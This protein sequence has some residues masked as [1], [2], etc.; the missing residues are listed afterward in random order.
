MSCAVCGGT[1]LRPAFAAM[2]VS[3]RYES[4]YCRSCRMY[5]TIGDIAPV[6]PD[7]VDLDAADLDAPHR[8]LQTTHK[9][10]A[11][12]QW[13]ALVRPQ[14]GQQLLEIG[15]G[16]GGFLD[17]AAAQGVVVYGFDASHA[18]AAEARARHA[19]V[20]AAASIDEYAAQLADQVSFNHVVMWDVFEHLRDPAHLLVELRERMAPGGQL[21]IS[22]PNAGPVAAK[23]AFG[24]ALGRPVADALIPWEHVFYHSRKSLGRLLDAA[25]WRL[26]RTGGVATYVRPWSAAEA[27]RRVAHRLLRD[28]PYA[29]QI[30]AVAVIR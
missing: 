2:R 30:Y 28:T 20:A 22:V 24:T 12:E 27:A 16:I 26:A 29:F 9:L 17:F 11:F 19:H 5:Q 1:D 18:Q 4:R 15:C 14:P 10:P 6:S 3:V 25:G 21:F 23:L 13:A 7:Y 8:F